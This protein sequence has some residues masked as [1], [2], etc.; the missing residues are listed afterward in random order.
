MAD[1][2]QLVEMT[3]TTTEQAEPTEEFDKERAM[4]TIR[5][6]RERERE[7]E[8]L[9]KKLDA[10]EKAE[11]QRKE[12]E[13]SETE[14]L[15]AQL[16]EVT[17]KA[18]KLE[19]E[20]LQRRAA[21]EAGLPLVFADRV[22]GESYEDML[23]DAKKLLEAIPTVKTPQ[24]PKVAPTNPGSGQ[25]KVESD[26]ELKARLH[27]ENDVFDPAFMKAHG[28]GIIFTDKE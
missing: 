26:K 21:D 8:K 7:A 25:P 17:E 22:R 16:A 20:T 12:A 24:T 5:K 2:E 15:K 4:A 14:K 28:G 13:M 6:L 18:T 10:Y 27:K 3:E 11:A 19:R 9:A 1:T 23:A